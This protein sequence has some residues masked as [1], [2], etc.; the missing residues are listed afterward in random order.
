MPGF[1]TR[2][3]SSPVPG[4]LIQALGTDEARG[5]EHYA[6]QHLANDADLRT[7]FRTDLRAATLHFVQNG[8]AESRVFTPLA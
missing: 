5:I 7:A 8:A 4:D 6:A 1:P 3:R 2:R